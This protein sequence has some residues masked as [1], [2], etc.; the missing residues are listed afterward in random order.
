MKIHI[1]SLGCRLNQSEIQSI[2]SV[3]KQNGHLL[4]NSNRADVFIINSCVVT[5]ASERKTRTLIHHA[6]RN[7]GPNGHVIVTGCFVE[8][9]SIKDNIIFLSN[10]YKYLI[11]DLI[12]NS[13]ILPEDTFKNSRFSF[14]PAIDSTRTRINLKIQDGCNNYCSYCIIPYVRGNPISRDIDSILNEFKLLRDEGYHEFLLTGVMI[15][16]YNY[17]GN[18]LTDLLTKLLNATGNFRIH[19]SSLSP[20][21][22]DQNFIDLLFDNKIVKHLH[23]SLQSGCDTILKSM[24]RK[25][26]TEQYLDILQKIRSVDKLFNFTTDLIT[27]FPGETDS[28]FQQTLIFLE[29]AKF[30]HIHTFRYSKRQ[31][32]AAASF[33]NQVQES[34]KKERSGIVMNISDRHNRDYLELFDKHKTTVLTEKSRNGLTRGYNEYYV[35]VHLHQEFPQNTFIDIICD[36]NRDRNTLYGSSYK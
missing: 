31:G 3:L 36:Y 30:S 14:S 8:S 5:H 19:L 16:N 21:T 20:Q 17:N 11:P 18:N 25:Y 34:V 33:Q 28:C 32:T 9:F 27:G 35:P 6:Q 12:D 29:Q 7:A 26:T 1:N 13:F 22:I 4:T 23:L 10:D 15:S 24:N 2:I